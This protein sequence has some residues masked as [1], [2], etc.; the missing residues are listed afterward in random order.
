[1]KEKV[2]TTTV[3]GEQYTKLVKSHT[4]LLQ[5]IRDEL[6]LTG[7]KEGC[8][9]GECGACTVLF[10]GHPV[11]SCLVLAVEADGHNI[12][13][14][15]GL[16]VD[17]SLHPLQESF[18][19]VGAVQCGYCTPGMLLSAKAILDENPDPTED[20]IRK[21]IEGNLCRCTGYNRIVQAIQTAGKKLSNL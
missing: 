6:Y 5:F 4:T 2:I 15:E 20:E 21:G 14:V 19:E 1:M 11:N 3:N 10:D 16:S 8:N 12:L 18:I 7:T 13:T 9:E 17:G